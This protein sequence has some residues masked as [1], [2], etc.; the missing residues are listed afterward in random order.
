MLLPPMRSPT[1]LKL[2]RFAVGLLRL[3]ST[4]LQGRGR[5]K[6]GPN[7]ANAGEDSGAMVGGIYGFGDDAGKV[8]L[9]P[10]N[11]RKFR[12]ETWKSQCLTRAACQNPSQRNEHPKIEVSA[13]LGGPLNGVVTTSFVKRSPCERT[14][15]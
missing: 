13:A 7:L 1:R 10:Q 3:W 9:H 2:G 14:R 11:M 6:L 12:S 4:S 8:D 5:A 15:C